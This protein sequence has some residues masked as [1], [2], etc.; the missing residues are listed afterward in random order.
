[1][2][3]KVVSVDN[4]HKNIDY[5]SDFLA[6]WLFVQSVLCYHVKYVTKYIVL[7]QLLVL[8][9]ITIVLNMKKI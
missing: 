9:I 5:S 4:S 2:C 6:L 8:E 3:L 7:F 1:M